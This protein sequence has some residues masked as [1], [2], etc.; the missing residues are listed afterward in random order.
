MKNKLLIC[1][2][3]MCS[4]LNSLA[5]EKKQDSLE[6]RDFYM[7]FAVPD[8]TAFSI[9]N[10]EPTS[11]SKPGS[12]KELALGITNF[13]NEKG[14]LRAGLAVEWA[15][16]KTFNKKTGNWEN[17]SKNQ[18]KFEWKNLTTSLATTNDSTNV[19]FA[20]AFR[21]SPIDQTNPLNDKI[22]V[23]SISNYFYSV[24]NQKI[25]Q[26]EPF[27]AARH[28]FMMSANKTFDRMEIPDSLREKLF[29]PI[30]AFNSNRLN[31][32]KAKYESTGVIFDRKVVSDGIFEEMKALFASNKLGGKFEENQEEIEQLCL[33]FTDF[34]Y[35]YHSRTSFQTDFNLHILKMKEEYK[36]K[37]WNKWA[38]QISAG[39]SFN[40]EKATLND[41]KVDCYAIAIT[42]GF[43]LI[44]EKWFK[45]TSFNSFMRNHS[46]IILQLK[47]QQYFTPNSVQNNSL[48][49]GARVLLGNYDNRFSFET[50]YIYQSNDLTDFNQK[51]IR[52]S[53]GAEIEIMDNYWLEFAIGGQNFEDMTGVN[54]LPTFAF[55]HSFGNEN[56]FFKK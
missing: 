25:I 22:W 41:L 1:F 48:S 39:E 43:P 52:Y 54:I 36:Q 50:A 17:K 3:V 7:D 31:S 38:L 37:N 8:I 20:G 56:R 30:D 21:F 6:I 51:G 42:T 44:G 55:R 29:M 45:G 49:A 34:F 16:F 12:I 40:S 27:D 2:V 35:Y 11:I 10:I 15:P 14:D 26:E 13:V 23:D 28:A 19:K 33:S 24:I 18:T 32:L 5:Q 53:V 47:T 9:L 4:S 46:Q